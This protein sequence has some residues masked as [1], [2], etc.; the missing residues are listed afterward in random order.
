MYK[1]THKKSCFKGGS[2]ISPFFYCMICMILSGFPLILFCSVSD[3]KNCFS[4]IKSISTS[5]GHAEHQFA[6]QNTQHWINTLWSL[7]VPGA[8]VGNH[9]IKRML[10]E[11]LLLLHWMVI[12]EY[13]S[14]KLYKDVIST[15]ILILLHQTW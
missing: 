7:V 8:V 1:I 14:C 11:R 13:I 2:T 9:C 3:R 12:K 4:V 15:G 5:E 10:K 6:G